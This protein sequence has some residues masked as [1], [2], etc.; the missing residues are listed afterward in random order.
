[1]DWAM[2]VQWEYWDRPLDAFSAEVVE[3]WAV[4]NTTEALLRRRTSTRSRTREADALPLPRHRS[5]VQTTRGAGLPRPRAK[6]QRMLTVHFGL[7]LL[8]SGWAFA[9][10]LRKH[11]VCS[12]NLD[13]WGWGGSSAIS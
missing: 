4:V 8:T 5:K 12:L 3:V 11:A 2:A 10:G 13:P 1:M 6:T 7:H 9:S